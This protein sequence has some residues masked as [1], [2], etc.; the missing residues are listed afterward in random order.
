M[1]AMDEVEEL[2]VVTGRNAETESSSAHMIVLQFGVGPAL[3]G[4]DMVRALQEGH[5]FL[6]CCEPFDPLVSHCG[7]DLQGRA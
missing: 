6:M 3:P 1:D 2:N 5:A 7:T 4:M